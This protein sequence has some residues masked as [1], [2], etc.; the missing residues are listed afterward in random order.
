VL[1]ADWK[2]KK[3]KM[4]DEDEPVLTVCG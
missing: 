1:E 3:R 2:K 4:M